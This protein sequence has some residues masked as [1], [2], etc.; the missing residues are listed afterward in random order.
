MKIRVANPNDA[1]TIHGFVSELATFERNPDGVKLS[2]E[3]YK[4]YLGSGACRA[5]VADVDNEPVGMGVFYDRFSTWVGPYLY[6]EDLY[7]NPNQRGNGVGEQL[8]R[9]IAGTALENG[10]QRMELMV[11]DWNPAKRLYERL[12][13]VVD[14]QWQLGQL[15]RAGIE[16]LATQIDKR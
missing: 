9:Y 3:D 13:F 8:V 4:K 12:G 6:I 14:P 10:M 1:E 16:T 2:A 7:V 11:L 15:S 5:V